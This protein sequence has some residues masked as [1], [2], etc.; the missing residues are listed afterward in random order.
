MIYVRE[1]EGGHTPTQRPAHITHYKSHNTSTHMTHNAL[2]HTTNGQKRRPLP[3]HDCTYLCLAPRPTRARSSRLLAHGTRGARQPT[4]YKTRRKRAAPRVHGWRAASSTQDTP[5]PVPMPLAPRWPSRLAC[6]PWRTLLCL[7]LL[8]THHRAQMQMVKRCVLLAGTGNPL[9]AHHALEARRQAAMN[10]F[11]RDGAAGCQPAPNLGQAVTQGCDRDAYEERA[12]ERTAEQP[13][14]LVSLKRQARA[15]QRQRAGWAKG[16]RHE[17]GRGRRRGQRR[18]GGRRGGREDCGCASAARVLAQRTTVDDYRSLLGARVE[19]AHVV[20]HQQRGRRRK[21]VAAHGCQGQGRRLVAAQP[22]HKP[23]RARS[24]AV[25]R[26]R[27]LFGAGTRARA[28]VEH[29]YL[30][31]AGSVAGGSPDLPALACGE[32]GTAFGEIDQ[33]ER[34][35]RGD[36]N[37]GAAA[38]GCRGRSAQVQLPLHGPIARHREECPAGVCDEQQRL[39]PAGVH[40]HRHDGRGRRGAAGGSIVRGFNHG[41]LHGN[42]QDQRGRRLRLIDPA[43][44]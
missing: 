4:N 41:D 26:H 24:P 8:R 6:A 20:R 17:R 9:H 3:R 44:T 19:P 10:I 2:A 28:R 32:R 30:T 7:K 25:L 12:A 33:H 15:E 31:A 23:A 39:P 5:C 43:R 29:E 22:L 42:V 35:G 37:D 16:H 11:R 21:Q 27:R 1:R 40:L 18:V 36:G 34:V 14:G 38:R 13:F